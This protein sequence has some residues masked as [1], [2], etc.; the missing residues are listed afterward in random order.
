MGDIPFFNGYQWSNLNTWNTWHHG[1]HDP[2]S[3]PHPEWVTGGHLPDLHRCWGGLVDLAG[4][5]P[6]SSGD[7]GDQRFH[8]NAL[9]I[10]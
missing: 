4:N 3:K 6:V 9:I 5:W 10:C 8:E 1:T 2:P 7:S